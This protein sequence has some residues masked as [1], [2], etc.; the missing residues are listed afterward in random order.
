MTKPMVALVGRPN[1]G[2]STLFNR[3]IGERLAI[4]EDVAGTTRDRL[5]ADADWAGREFTVIDTGGL[6]ITPGSDLLRRVREQAELAVREADVIVFLVDG[7][8]GASTEDSEIAALLRQSGKP[9]VVCV[10]KA[11]NEQRRLD[12]VEF[13]SLGVE[14]I[15]P[16]SALHGTGTGDLLDRVVEQM[17]RIAEE[18]PEPGI[19]VA[20]V[21]RPNVGK[22]SILNSIL[23][24]ERAVVSEVPGTTRDVIDTVIQH[25]DQRFVLLDTAGVRRRGRV[26]VGVEKYSVI[27]TLRAID[28]CDLAFLVIDAEEGIT[29]QDTH[30]AG[31]IQ[32]AHKGMAIVV[33]KWDLVTPKTSQSGGEYTAIVREEFRFAPWAPIVFTSATTGRAIDQLLPLAAEIYAERQL[34]IPTAGLNDLVQEAV[35]AHSPA[36]NKGRR[37]RIYYATQVSVNPPTF[38]FSVNDPTLAHFTYVRYLENRIRQAFAFTGTPLKMFFRPHSIREERPEG[39]RKRT[40]R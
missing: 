38:V 32:D 18:E 34:R 8:V 5:Y 37:L 33:N 23:G 36:S 1:V 6:E 29:A 11:D 7:R 17:P 24:E 22:S 13:Y 21:G 3:I 4:T 15:F 26:E 2:K 27:R 28:R 30:L 9:V 39:R 40:K 16:I 10:N 20:I 12:A 19:H 31:F 14:E 25:G 35:A